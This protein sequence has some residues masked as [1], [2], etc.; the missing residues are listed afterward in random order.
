MKTLLHSIVIL[1]SLYGTASAE[2]VKC[3][4]NGKTVYSNDPADCGKNTVK[5]VKG[6][7]STFPKPEPINRSSARTAAVIPTLPAVTDPRAALERLGVSPED[8]ANGWNVIKDAQQRGSWQAPVM[9]D[10]LR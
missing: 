1:L 9:P 7:V 5:A 8:V 10:E 4:V 2:L 3:V 6:N